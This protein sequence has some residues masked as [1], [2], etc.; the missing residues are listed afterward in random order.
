VGGVAAVAGHA[1]DFVH[2]L[3]R[4]RIV[5]PAAAAIAAR[6]AEPADARPRAD[7]PAVVALADRVDDANH[8]VAWHAR[9]LD[10]WE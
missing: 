7:A 8:L 9:I 4:E 6:A 5:A 10:D 3:A 1:A 2:I